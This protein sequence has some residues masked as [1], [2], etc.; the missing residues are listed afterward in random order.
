M[1]NL[2]LLFALGAALLPAAPITYTFTQLGSG[3]LGG[4]L[5]SDALVTLTL[6]GDT[7]G[8]VN[9]NPNLFR[10]PGSATV[11]VDGLG[12]ADFTIPMRV[13]LN[14]SA[15]VVGISRATDERDLIGLAPPVPALTTYRLDLP[16]GLT[17]GT[18]A[19]NPSLL[20]A[21]TAGDFV[22]STAQTVNRPVTFSASLNSDVPE[23]STIGL[24]SV[25][26]AA[27]LL[28]RRKQ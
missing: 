11:T 12:T 5:F 3:S 26:L 10:N 7:T 24:I 18:P 1:R 19:G 6:T 13:F 8:I 4:T 27:L 2:L 28:R 22:L 23:P 14:P 15:T 16:I 25:G 9:P 21:T 20:F 17:T